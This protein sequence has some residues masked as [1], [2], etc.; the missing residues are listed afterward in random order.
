[1]SFFGCCRFYFCSCPYWLLLRSIKTSLALLDAAVVVIVDI[2]DVVNVVV[3]V[4][5][6]VTDHSIF[7]CGR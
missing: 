7:S 4:L 6:A 3:G 1:M 5:L 2:V